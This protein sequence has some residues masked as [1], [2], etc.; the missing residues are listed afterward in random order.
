MTMADST[1]EVCRDEEAVGV[2]ALPGAPMSVAY[3]RACLENHAIPLWLADFTIGECVPY[4]DLGW[5]HVAEWFREHAVP[6]DGGYKRVDEL[7]MVVGT[8]DMCGGSGRHEDGPTVQFADGSEYNAC[9]GCYKGKV[10]RLQE[11]VD[12]KGA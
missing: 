2:A 7:T 3:G 10:V 9:M 8:C 5:H 12:A 1:C 4:D 11:A 6:L